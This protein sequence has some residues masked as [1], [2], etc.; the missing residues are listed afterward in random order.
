[1]S[2]F[3]QIF[4]ESTQP[5][6][7]VAIDPATSVLS[8]T[9]L[10]RATLRELFRQTGLFGRD[11]D[12]APVEQAIVQ[13]RLGPIP[14]V[15]ARPVLAPTDARLVAL[16]GFTDLVLQSRGRIGAQAEAQLE[17]AGFSARAVSEVV[18]VVRMAQDV[19]GI[20]ANPRRG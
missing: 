6:G 5:A 14:G 11:S 10:G 9:G 20:A 18:R 2:F 19:F 3:S 4:S 12:L 8:A 7:H 15:P 1:M 13:S 17:A 16:E